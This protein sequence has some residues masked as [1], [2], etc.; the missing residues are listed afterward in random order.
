[1]N[2]KKLQLRCG[3]ADKIAE[4]KCLLSINLNDFQKFDAGSDGSRVARTPQTSSKTRGLAGWSALDLPNRRA[5]G[6][7]DLAWCSTNLTLLYPSF[8]QYNNYTA[9]GGHEK[10]E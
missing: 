6:K 3:E 8:P 2:F 5:S 7:Y 1:M 4:I 10:L 9:L